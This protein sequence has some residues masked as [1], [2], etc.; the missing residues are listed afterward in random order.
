M[1]EDLR[2]QEVGGFLGA[3][4]LWELAV[5]PMLLNNAE[6]WTELSEDAVTEIENLQLLFLT[7]LF[8][9]PGSTPKPILLWDTGILSMENRVKTRKLNLAIHIKKQNV[10]CL[11]RQVFDEQVRQ[12]WPG[13]TKEVK[14][15]CGEWNI[16]DV[17]MRWKGEPSKG[18]WKSIIREAARKKNEKE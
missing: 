13:L 17:T 15:I 2:M 9:V 4:D 1:M 12:G 14:E 3:I 16:T 5:V 18:K 7:T 6:M 10:E 8:E 11:S